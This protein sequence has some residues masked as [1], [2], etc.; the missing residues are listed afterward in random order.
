[1]MRML[2]CSRGL[3]Q[4][5]H[6][7]ESRE[8]EALRRRIRGPRPR[9]GWRVGKGG[10]ALELHVAVAQSKACPKRYNPFFLQ[11]EKK[12]PNQPNTNKQTKQKPTTQMLT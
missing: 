11:I 6:L 7:E 3:G 1:M 8:A 4:E 2:S 9:R 5:D 12:K 10:G